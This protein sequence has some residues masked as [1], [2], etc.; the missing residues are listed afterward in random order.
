MSMQVLRIQRIGQEK[1]KRIRNDAHS[2]AGVRERVVFSLRHLII[3]IYF[4]HP[5]CQYLLVLVL[6]LPGSKK[7]IHFSLRIQY[8]ESKVKFHSLDHYLCP[9]DDIAGRVPV[10]TALVVHLFS[11]LDFLAKFLLF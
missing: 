10:I 9:D 5:S 3:S 2:D 4:P 1:E 7:C 6:F 8:F 11:L